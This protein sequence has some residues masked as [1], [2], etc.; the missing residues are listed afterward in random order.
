MQLSSMTKREWESK[1]G[2]VPGGG[3]MDMENAMHAIVK[4]YILF[5]STNAIF[6][7]NEDANYNRSQRIVIIETI[8]YFWPQQN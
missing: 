6:T 2:A 1:K 7:Q 5:S 8:L 3:V 4:I